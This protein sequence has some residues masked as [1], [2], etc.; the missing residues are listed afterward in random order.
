MADMITK[1]SV[2]KVS[3][4]IQKED[5]PVVEKTS[6]IEMDNIANPVSTP[7]EVD[8]EALKREIMKE[9]VGEMGAVEVFF[10]KTTIQDS[11][12]FADLLNDS[13][14]KL[15]M[16]ELEEGEKRGALEEVTINGAV[17]QIPKG[18]SVL[19]PEQ[20]ANMIE[21]YKKA[22]LTAGDKIR[23]MSGN[24]GVRADRDEAT[25]SALGL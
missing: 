13:P 12:R 9:V 23:N 11:K 2:K 7:T 10:M 16:W 14:K 17:A 24:L 5:T 19:V 21:G 15:A 3:T 25:K 18:V 20:V 1:E 6:K 4:P 8:R 22:E